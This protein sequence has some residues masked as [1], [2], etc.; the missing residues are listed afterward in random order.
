[1]GAASRERLPGTGV[2]A[3]S[4]VFVHGPRVRSPG[5]LPEVTLEMQEGRVR[6]SPSFS[7]PPWA[8]SSGRA[9]HPRRTASGSLLACLLPICQ[10]QHSPTSRH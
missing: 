8:V 2:R 1:M 7:Q 5:T 3:A 10:L 6:R 9:R 4:L